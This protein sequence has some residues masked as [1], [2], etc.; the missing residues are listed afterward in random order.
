MIWKKLLTGGIEKVDGLL[1][2]LSFSL[3]SH[4]ICILSLPMHFVKH[5]ST[6]IRILIPQFPKGGQKVSKERGGGG[7]G[8]GSSPCPPLN[9]T[10][11]WGFR[12][13]LKAHR[14]SNNMDTKFT[15]RGKKWRLQ[16]CQKLFSGYNPL[17]VSSTEDKNNKIN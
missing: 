2:R 17:D 3:L 5:L 12:Y 1:R 16:I 10:L 14:I 6:S 13:H 7:G 4:Y 8:E 11:S 9:R 15:T